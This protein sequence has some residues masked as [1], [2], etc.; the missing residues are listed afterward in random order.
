MRRISGKISWFGGKKDITMK[1]TESLALYPTIT[2][3]WMDYPFLNQFYCA[4]RWD[5][6]EIAKN[7]VL[8]RSEVKDRLRNAEIVVEFQSKFMPV[9]PVDWGPHPKTGRIIDVSK[10]VM[11]KFGCQTDDT[12]IIYLP[13]WVRLT[14]KLL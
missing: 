11:G 14:D 10:T 6:D 1:P 7:L 9:I 8:S 12:V 5:Y 2:R 4:M 13:N 3:D